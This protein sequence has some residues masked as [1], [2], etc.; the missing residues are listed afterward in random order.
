[1]DQTFNLVEMVRI[2]L[3]WKKPLII[4]IL[5]GAIGSVVVAFSLPVY[6]KS[7]AT[8]YPTN[9]SMT[10]RQILFSQDTKENY[11]EYF[12]TK[13]DV[14]RVLTIARSAQLSNFIIDSFNLYAHYGIDREN[15]VYPITAVFKEFN[16]NYSSIKTELAA[17]EITLFDTDPKKAADMVNA[18]TNRIDLVNKA[19]I[20]VNKI[21][22]L[23]LFEEQKG[24]KQKEVN[25]LTDSLASVGEL[26]NIQ[27]ITSANG[28]SYQYKGSSLQGVETYKVLHKIH[29]NA[30]EELTTL[31]LLHNQYLLSSQDETSSLQ[32][33]ERAYPAEK[34]SKPV[35]WLF[36]VVIT[37]G[38]LFFALVSV[39]LIEKIYE[40][41]AELADAG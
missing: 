16:D 17:V 33:V 5:L 7:V 37:F 29:E 38:V 24:D 10:D 8:F 14:E 19:M 25:M 11:V 35:R 40:V 18:I 22:I 31:T 28:E 34:K 15:D 36:C 4:V 27:V 39:I 2:F 12:G 13:K 32:I 20:N 23:D 21:H 9:P 3:K 30:V 26:H 1:M 41:K 6:Y